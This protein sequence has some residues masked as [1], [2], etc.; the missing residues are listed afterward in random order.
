[1]KHFLGLIN[2]TIAAVVSGLFMHS[3]FA[4]GYSPGRLRGCL[5]AGN[6]LPVS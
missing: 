3:L 1:M 4:G 5:C 2:I 6:A